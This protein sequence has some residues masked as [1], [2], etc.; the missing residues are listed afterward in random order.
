M[1]DLGT[2]DLDRRY[3]EWARFRSGN[4]L[5][6]WYCHGFVLSCCFLS[7]SL[8]SVVIVLSFCELVLVELHDYSESKKVWWSWVR[9]IV[10]FIIVFTMAGVASASYAFSTACYLKWP[11]LRVREGS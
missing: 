9:W 11:A 10:V 6:T 7:L 1:S 8:A 5:Y 4:E 3:E 2:V